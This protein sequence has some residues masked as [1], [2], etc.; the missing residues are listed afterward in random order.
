[1]SDVVATHTGMGKEGRLGNSL[2]ALQGGQL[3]Q[4]LYIFSV[5]VVNCWQQHFVSKTHYHKTAEEQPYLHLLLVHRR[6]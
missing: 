2:H 4:L 1:M 5:E 6:L 3:L